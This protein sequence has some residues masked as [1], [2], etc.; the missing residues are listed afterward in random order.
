MI[1]GS[2][3]ELR[4]I[5][6]DDLPVFEQVAF[7]DQLFGDISVELL[8]GFLKV[9]AIGK[10]HSQDEKESHSVEESQHDN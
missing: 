7:G 10:K 5:T 1:K 6:E 8:A 9:H 3:F 4:L 2:S